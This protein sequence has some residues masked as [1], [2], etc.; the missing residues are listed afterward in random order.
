MMPITAAA[1]APELMPIK[2]LQKKISV[3][4][5][6]NVPLDGA[7]NLPHATGGPAVRTGRAILAN[8]PHREQGVPSLRY[9]SHLSG[10]GLDVIGAG[11][12]F[13]PGVSLGHNGTIAFGLTIFAVDQ[14]ASSRSTRERYGWQPSHPSLLDDLAAVE[15]PV[16]E[17]P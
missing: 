13:L 1:L 15:R 7:P 12:P 5:Q 10:P 11:E 6:F 17:R 2:D 16:G 4:K 8:D 3:F 14:P 9:F